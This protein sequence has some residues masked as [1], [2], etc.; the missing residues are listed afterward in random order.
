MGAE[1]RVDGGQEV[2]A[3]VLVVVKGNAHGDPAAGGK[4]HEADTVRIDPPLHSPSADQAYR[5][6]TVGARQRCDAGDVGLRLLR[7]FLHQFGDGVLT[8]RH[9]PITQNECGHTARVQP[10]RNVIA[11]A[12]DGQGVVTAARRDDHRG[13]VALIGRRQEGRER[14]SGNVGD[15][16]RLEDVGEVGA[17]FVCPVLA[18]GRGSLVQRDDVQRAGVGAGGAHV[19]ARD[20]DEK[21]KQTGVEDIDGGYS[22]MTFS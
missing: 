8:P 14:G 3:G 1:A 6:D 19:Q 20:T 21:Q 17:L 11:L 15:H 18:A 10:A 16:F 22:W 7:R 9:Q 5:L 4:A 12:V 13:A 2:G